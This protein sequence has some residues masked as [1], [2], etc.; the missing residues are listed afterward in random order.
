MQRSVALYHYY[1]VLTLQLYGSHMKECIVIIE[2]AT[3]FTCVDDS[4]FIFQIDF[5]RRSLNQ[6]LQNT[7]GFLVTFITE[8]GDLPL[9]KSSNNSVHVY[10]HTDG[11]KV[12]ATVFRRTCYIY[13]RLSTIFVDVFPPV[14]FGMQRNRFRALR[15]VL[16]YEAIRQVSSAA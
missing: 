5:I 6:C 16:R 14:E 9:M 2:R 8:L 7:G 4:P 1:I 13:T 3:H 12:S 15:S 10:N 11:T